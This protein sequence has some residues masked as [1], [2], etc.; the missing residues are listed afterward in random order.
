MKRRPSSLPAKPRRNR[1][2]VIKD[3]DE[4]SH[5]ETQRRQSSHEAVS[6][7]IEASDLETTTAGSEAVIDLTLDDAQVAQVSKSKRPKI[8]GTQRNMDSGVCPTYV[9]LTY[10]LTR[11]VSS[12][13]RH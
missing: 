6:D 11:L 3:D 9:S 2:R 13:R 12:R 5:L 8:E 1:R 10:H 4:S 7:D